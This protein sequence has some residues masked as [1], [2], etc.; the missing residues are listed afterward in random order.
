MEKIRKVEIV[1]GFSC[2]NFCKFCSVRKL[3]FDKT[4]Q[5]IKKDILTVARGH[6]FEI[7]FTGG[8]PTIRKDIFTLISFTK[9]L[10]IEEVRVTTNGRMFFYEKFTKT[11]VDCGLTGAIF[12][13]HAP[14]KEIHDYLTNVKGSFEQAIKGLRNLREYTDHIDVNVVI[15]TK[16]YK[17]LPKLAELVI[18]KYGVR[19]MCL[20][21]PT[22]DGNLLNNIYLLPSYEETKDFVI[23]ALDVIKSLGRTGWVLNMPVCFLSGYEAYSSL[24]ELRTK[25]IWPDAVVNL[26]EQRKRNMKKINV[27]KDCKFRLVCNGVSKDY[28][29][30]KG[31]KEIKPIRGRLVKSISEAYEYSSRV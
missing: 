12:S 13:I 14:V 11:I 9:N 30:I 1:T 6:P 25:M 19:A 29:R 2:N 7:N 22:I 24:S 20:I 10:G 5:Q 27:C 31:H 18:G 28:L 23:R 21:F 26:D 15:T 17:L 4:T 3:N 8:E 16:N